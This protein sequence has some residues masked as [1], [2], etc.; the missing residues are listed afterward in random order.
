MCS[1]N[2]HAGII[3]LP[4]LLDLRVNTCRVTAVEY[5]FAMFGVDSSTVWL[6]VRHQWSLY[7]C[8]GYRL[9][10]VDDCRQAMPGVHACSSRLSCHCPFP[11]TPMVTWYKLPCCDCCV[12]FWNKGVLW[13]HEQMNQVFF[14]LCVCVFRLWQQQ[15]C[16]GT[17][18]WWFQEHC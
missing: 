14:I 13:L 1:G 9:V 10:D 8:I 16:S 3:L 7:V 12:Y 15:S 6:Q 11:P 18:Q 5:I 17:V 2:S 4:W